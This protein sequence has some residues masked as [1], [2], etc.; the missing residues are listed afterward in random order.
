MAAELRPVRAVVVLQLPGRGLGRP[1]R[2]HR[3]GRRRVP[4]PDAP[5]H[6]A[7]LGRRHRELR[8]PPAQARLEGDPAP[9]LPAGAVAH[10]LR[11][12]GGVGQRPGPGQGQLPL[13]R[14]AAARDVPGSWQGDGPDLRQGPR[15]ELPRPDPAARA[16]RLAAAEA[17]PRQARRPLRRPA[18]LGAG[19]PRERRP[20]HRHAPRLQAGPRGTTHGDPGAAQGHADARGPARAPAVADLAGTPR[21]RQ[22]LGADGPDP[23]RGRQRRAAVPLPATQPP[24]HQRVVRHR[25]GHAGLEEARRPRATTGS[26]RTGRCAG[27]C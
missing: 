2:G 27:S 24:R 11:G 23:R 13:H 8:H 5:D 10:Q 18:L 17:A 9:L 19:L 7:P 14:R 1:D 15:H 20:G 16:R 6:R 3:R 4:R 26:S 22:R 25:G 21:L 12:D